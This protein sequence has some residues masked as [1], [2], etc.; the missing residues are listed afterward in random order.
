MLMMT[1]KKYLFLYLLSLY[2]FY[3]TDIPILLYIQI[4]RGM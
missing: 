2:P 4:N 3:K 1:E